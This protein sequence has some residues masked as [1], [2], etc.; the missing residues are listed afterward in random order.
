M[1]AFVTG[2]E[3]ILGNL[4]NNGALEA[5][6]EGCDIVFH[7]AST[8]G[9]NIDDHELLYRDNVT[10]THNVINA[11]LKSGVQRL[12]YVSSV[13]VLFDGTPLVDADEGA[14][15]AVKPVS[16]YA[17]TKAM[18]ECAVLGTAGLE[19]LVVR[20]PVVWGGGDSILPGL[21][22]MARHGLWVWPDAG[23][24]LISSLH[25]LNASAGIIMIGQKGIPGQI[26]NL[27]D[28]TRPTFKGLFIARLRN[29]GCASWQIGDS[30]FSR[31]FPAWIFWVL[32]VVCEFLWR[33][34]HLPGAPPIPREGIAIAS[35]EMTVRDNKARKLGYKAI[36]NWEEGLVHEGKW[37]RENS[38]K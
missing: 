35:N 19:V 8:L 21:V 15:L 12:L 3:P 30:V 22:R 11:A 31:N 29:A 25:V 34:L 23:R 38:Q 28:D 10:G 20:L 16:Y 37:I 27:C 17:E 6:M 14:P 32:V 13:T 26:Y 18:A 9:V 5:G 24:H 7:C 4:Q 1:Q 2:A 33:V 36:V